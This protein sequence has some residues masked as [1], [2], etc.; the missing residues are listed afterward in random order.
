[1]VAAPLDDG[2]RNPTIAKTARKLFMT[3]P[4]RYGRTAA[5]R[6]KNRCRQFPARPACDSAGI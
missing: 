2:T 6:V 1:M 4:S 5:L 3:I